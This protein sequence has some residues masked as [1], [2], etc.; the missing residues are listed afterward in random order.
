MTTEE[1]GKKS[2]DI[3]RGDQTI[4]DLDTNSHVDQTGSV[5]PDQYR[6]IIA[7]H[8]RYSRQ[9][10]I[11]NGHARLQQPQQQGVQRPAGHLNL[12]SSNPQAIFLRVGR[13]RPPLFVRHRIVRKALEPR[14]HHVRSGRF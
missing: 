10:R 3:S 14:T 2:G 8:P 6:T 7:L 5:S 9:S 12:G 11:E 13:Q 4:G 1:D